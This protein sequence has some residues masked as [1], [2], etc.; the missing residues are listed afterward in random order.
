MLLCMIPRRRVRDLQRGAHLVGGAILLAFVYVLP[1]PALLAVLQ[2]FVVPVL[3]ASGLA[4]WKWPRI[5]AA[6]RRVT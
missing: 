2:W 3:L 1:A 5:R 4:L 6:L